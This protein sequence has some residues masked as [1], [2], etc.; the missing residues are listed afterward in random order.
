ML[1]ITEGRPSKEWT[2]LDLKRLAIDLYN[3][4]RK[5]QEHGP[6]QPPAEP[7]EPEGAAEAYIAE[8]EKQGPL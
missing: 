5:A 4:E 8:L 1:K 2:E 3:R 7:P 6:V